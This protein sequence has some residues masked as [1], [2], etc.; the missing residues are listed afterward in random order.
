MINALSL[1]PA[2]D[3]RGPVP[4]KTEGPLPLSLDIDEIRVT[5]GKLSFSDLSGSKPFETVLSPTEASI[6]HFSLGKDKKSTYMLST[7]TE[8]K[9]TVKGQGQFSVDPLWSEGTVEV[10]SLTLKKYSPYYSD[11]VLFGIE[12]GRLDLSTHYRYAAGQKE[13]EINLSGMSLSLSAL[14]LKKAGDKRDFLKIPLF[15]S[16]RQTWTSRAES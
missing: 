11:H 5:G 8:A 9:E 6:D 7:Q 2:K 13:P 1:L 15:S 16:S 3:E 14:R 12:D 10:A 4:K